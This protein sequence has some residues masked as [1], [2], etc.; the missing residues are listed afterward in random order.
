MPTIGKNKPACK[1]YTARDALKTNKARKV[2]KAKRV[3]GKRALKAFN[4]LQSGKKVKSR[5]TARVNGTSRGNMPNGAHTKELIPTKEPV[6]FN[7]KTR[8]WVTP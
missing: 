2:A 6:V 5:I 1:M 3:A 4:R 8:E 7:V